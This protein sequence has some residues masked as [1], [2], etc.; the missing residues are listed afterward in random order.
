LLNFTITLIT[1]FFLLDYINM[2]PW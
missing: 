1:Q 2:L